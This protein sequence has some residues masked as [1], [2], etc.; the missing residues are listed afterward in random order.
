LKIFKNLKDKIFKNLKNVK[1]F[2]LI[3]KTD[4]FEKDSV[5]KTFQNVSREILGYILGNL[6]YNLRKF[7]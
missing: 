5:G 6:G 1:K 2:D 4:E 3:F 7:S